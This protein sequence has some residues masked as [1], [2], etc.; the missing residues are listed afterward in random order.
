[1]IT[2]MLF[3][4]S[5]IIFLAFFLKCL[6]HQHLLFNH[7]SNTSITLLILFCFPL[8]YLNTFLQ[9]FFKHQILPKSVLKKTNSLLSAQF[10]LQKPRQYNV[11]VYGLLS[12]PIDY[13]EQLC[14]LYYTLFH[15][16]L[17]EISIFWH[18]VNYLFISSY[19]VHVFVF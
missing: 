10:E 11:V 13:L 14:S 4:C 2:K 5:Q 1:M 17:F 8:T 3:F 18:A 15:Q 9:N 19:H 12:Q 6:Y 16:V 7:K